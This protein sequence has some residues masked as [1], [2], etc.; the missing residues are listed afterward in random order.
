MKTSVTVKGR[1]FISQR[2][3]N[4]EAGL[5]EP[6]P[7]TIK[8]AGYGIWRKGAELYRTNSD[9]FG[10]EL[11]TAG[12]SSYEQ[13]G[14]AFHIAPHTAYIKHLGSS[15]SMKVGNTGFLC[16]RMVRIDGPLLGVMLEQTGLRNC[17]TIAFSDSAVF[18]NLFKKAARLC[19]SNPSALYPLSALAYEM[20]IC[21]ASCLQPAGLPEPIEHACAHINAHLHES[22]HVETLAEASG[23]S[24]A[25]FYRQFEK[26]MQST[27]IEYINRRKV[28]RA[29][30]M[31]A[32]TF[33]SAKEIAFALGFND[34]AYFSKVFKGE[35][36]TTPLAYRTGHLRL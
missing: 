30:D 29:K 18:K 24:R 14:N 27:P 19:A 7:L 9:I 32:H 36:G 35:C 4:A 23:L 22:L 3:W 1:Q 5:H 6:F 2:I 13:D 12:D 10:F 20:I 34:P 28:H 25:Q 16:K 21:A 8:Y 33:M 11:I 31:L 15:H 26:H 17:H